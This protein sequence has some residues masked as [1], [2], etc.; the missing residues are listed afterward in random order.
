MAG[1]HYWTWR[2]GNNA[3]LLAQ[4]L[5]SRMAFVT[6]VPR[7]EDVGADFLCSLIT[8]HSD[9]MLWAGKAFCVQVKS[10]RDP[11]IYDKPH[12]VQWL[13]KLETPL[14]IGLC[15]IPH[16]QLELY[17]T[18]NLMNAY[19]LKSTNSVVLR[20]GKAP[21]APG[22]DLSADV[23][24]DTDNDKADVY[25]GDPVLRL[26]SDEMVDDE[27]VATYSRILRDWLNWEGVNIAHKNVGLYYVLCPP[28]YQTNERLSSGW[29]NVWFYFNPDNYSVSRKNFQDASISLL[30]VS[31]AAAKQ[32]RAVDNQVKFAEK[33][34]A[35]FTENSQLLFPWE[36]ERFDR[37]LG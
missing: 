13:T 19:L 4:Y 12:E 20:F 33:L 32:G 27:I 22:D 8:R 14:Y 29:E 1:G 6:S 15:D 34:R 9:G 26:T 16:H 10:N 2:V 21:K 30:M 36:K 31:E 7:Q 35:F 37:L 17:S 18:W 24:F 25:L 23:R 28:P 3:E 11:I 5:L